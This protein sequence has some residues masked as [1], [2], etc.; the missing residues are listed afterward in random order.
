MFIYIYK[1]YI[2]LIYIQKAHFIGEDNETQRWQ[3][4][5]KGS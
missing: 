5:I 3:R 2:Y 1:I 4:L